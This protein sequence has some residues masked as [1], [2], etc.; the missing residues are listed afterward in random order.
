MQSPLRRPMLTSSE[1]NVMNRSISTVFSDM[2]SVAFCRALRRCWAGWAS[3]H[4]HLGP[5][6]KFSFMG[7]HC[8]IP[9]TAASAAA[10]VATAT[11]I[12]W[13]GSSAG[14]DRR[15]SSLVSSGELSAGKCSSDTTSGTSNCHFSTL[16]F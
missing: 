12:A 13:F 10:A 14:D 3:I 11:A 9:A 15:L 6:S 2:L 16:S 8:N 7:S 1:P 4:P 5:R